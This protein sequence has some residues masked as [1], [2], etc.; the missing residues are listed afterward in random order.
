MNKNSILLLVLFL[1]TQLIGIG[2]LLQ[3]IDF[4][5]SAKTGETQLT[6]NYVIAPPQV[7]DETYSF[8]SIFIAIILG[9]VMV[10]LLIKYGK[11]LIWKLWF[12]ASIAIGLFYALSPFFS[13]HITLAIICI[14]LAY[15]KIFKYNMYVHTFTELFVYA[16]IAAIFVP[17]L[18]IYSA[19][20]LFIVLGVYDWWMVKKSG[21]MIT[22]AQAQLAQGMIT[23]LF[24]SQTKPEPV[25]ASSHTSSKTGKGKKSEAGSA[26]VGGGDITFPLFFA[27]AAMKYFGTVLPGVFIAIGATIGLFVLFYRSKPGTFYPAIPFVGVGSFVGFL[28]AFLL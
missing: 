26:M 20:I 28:L 15:L 13:W 11:M 1:L 3:Y 23:G 18:N 24:V 22:L 17:I 6:D 9:T 25:K 7:G 27:G 4:A 14:G 10:L 21:H 8:I 2:V 5:E 16:G 12:L 19:G